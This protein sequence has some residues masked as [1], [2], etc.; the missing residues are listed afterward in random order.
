[1]SDPYGHLAG[2]LAAL[3]A[4][5]VA[6]IQTGRTTRMMAR[7]KA[8]DQLVV[9]SSQEKHLAER[10]LRNAM[11]TGVRII[12]CPPNTRDVYSRVGTPPNGQTHFSHVWWKLWT[13]NC[14]MSLMREA[15]TIQRDTSKVLPTPFHPLA[16][17]WAD[18]SED[19]STRGPKK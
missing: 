6:S 5:D 18:L 14:L 16:R 11:I 19:R 9:H 10:T 15:A 7:I 3:Q 4:F 8:G 12:I 13:E 1:M 2:L 17:T